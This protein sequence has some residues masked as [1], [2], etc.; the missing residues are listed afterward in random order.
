MPNVNAIRESLRIGYVLKRYPRYSE[1]FVVNEILALEQRGLALDIF[2]LRPPCETHFQ[3]IIARVRAPVHYLPPRASR[4]VD[5]W[6][7]LQ[8]AA[9]WV[10]AERLLDAARDESAH[11]VYQAL[12]LAQIIRERGIG[13]LHA[14]FATSATGVARMAARFAG[15]GYSFTAHAKDIYHDS[16]IGDDLGRKLAEASA[17]VTVSDYNL[18][19]LRECFGD[20]RVARLYNGLD[21]DDFPYRSPADRP[22]HI[23]A[24][25]RLV[26]KK[27][28]ADLIDACSLLVERG[29]HF[30]CQLIGGG[31]LEAEL[32]ERIA[33]R[34]LQ[35]RVELTG[36]L[37]QREVVRRVQAGAVLAA[38]CVIGR[39]SN[40]DGLP[41]VL[42]EAMAL[43]TPCV[44]TDVTG[45]PEVLSDEVT[46]LQVPQHD[47]AAL[48][49][50]LERLLADAA[51]RVRLAEAAR[52]RIEQDFDV[53][54][55]VAGLQ[56]I[57]ARS[58][59]QSTNRREAVAS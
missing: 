4:A 15:I 13:H 37:P 56:R 1:T 49:A 6:E 42:L 43:G 31:E 52:Q 20:A 47:P 25:G 11:D 54:R 53:R 44:S 28:F 32:R 48:A 8:A 57:F 3:D 24:V 33:A 2:T 9:Q 51:L 30:D 7:A 55:N 50:A 12:L 16:V 41:T 34:G 35:Q 38:P 27:G 26:E 58:I 23:V 59:E 18:N 36:P 21:L 14:H 10:S 46:G 39:D 22:P 40:R 17:V 19:H 45:I 29:C 5:F